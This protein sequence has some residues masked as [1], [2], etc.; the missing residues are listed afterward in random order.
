MGFGEVIIIVILG[1]IFLFITAI[2]AAL[3][4]AFCGL[5]LGFTPL[6]TWTLNFLSAAHIETNMVDLGTFLGFAGGFFKAT[7]NIKS[8]S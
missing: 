8:D 4:G 1:V 2:L 3:I 5:V 7:T 6:G